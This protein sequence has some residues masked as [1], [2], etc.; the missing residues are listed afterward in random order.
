MAST[1][2]ALTRSFLGP[3]RQS[4]ELRTEARRWGKPAHRPRPLW[5]RV[6][7]VI[8]ETPSVKTFVLEP[9]D[10]AQGP[11]AYRAGQHLVVVVDVDGVSQRRCYSFSSS[12][13]SG[14]RP[15]ITVKRVTDGRV[16]KLLHE[17]IHVGDRLRVTPPAGSF[18]LDVSGEARRRYVLV[19]GGVGITP[20]A[21]L[22]ETILLAEPLSRVTLLF[23][24]RN[25]EEICFRS[26]L[27]NLADRFGERLRVCH[28]L[29]EPP[30]GWREANGRL[31]G[32][33]V[34]SL[35]GAPDADLYLLCGPPPMMESV[36]A[37]LRGAGV[38][39]DR[40]R[41]ERFAYA[42]VQGGGLPTQARGVRFAASGKV[43]TAQPGQTLLQAA[44][45]AGVA[46]PFSCT[47]G[48]CGA[49]KVRLKSGSVVM[50]EPNCLTEQERDQ[51]FVLTCCA[52]A[53][54]DVVI[55]GY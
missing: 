51:G 40:I 25:E 13:L 14:E 24:N 36:S 3:R 39:A 4:F 8:Q 29:E 32:A 50:S 27:A 55:E 30:S 22:A 15:A 31:D 7:E 10:P 44:N 33:R 53:A 28:V 12:P 46:L 42:A 5:L 34:L 21:S 45:D 52:Y 47:M 2:R 38:D 49:C 9:G 43:A 54:K 37:A 1:V 35:L 41:T 11:L 18:T 16:S 17:E 6:A 48:G 23:G 19:A 20:L 26:R